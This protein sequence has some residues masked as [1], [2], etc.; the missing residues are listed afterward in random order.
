MCPAEF[1]RMPR[2]ASRQRWLASHTDLLLQYICHSGGVCVLRRITLQCVTQADHIS[3]LHAHTH[4]W[5]LLPSGCCC[6]AVTTR[7]HAAS[8]VSGGN[9]TRPGHCDRLLWDSSDPCLLATHLSGPCSWGLMADQCVQQV[10][11][12][13]SARCLHYTRSR[14]GDHTQSAVGIK[15]QIIFDN[16]FAY[17]GLC[18]FA[19]LIKQPGIWC[20]FILRSIHLVIHP[21][22]CLLLAKVA[23]TETNV[24]TLVNTVRHT[25]IDHYN[26]IS[27]FYGSKF[28]FPIITNRID[29]YPYIT[30]FLYPRCMITTSFTAL[31]NSTLT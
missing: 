22:I 5:G 19:K 29:K 30:S 1:V 11:L 12:R 8:Q 27:G 23:K 18:Q 9:H 24:D 7:M 3:H 26:L 13:H 17:S 2:A 25:K 16:G 6:S 15:K 28:N 10:T 31:I 20:P 14:P 4:M 21:S